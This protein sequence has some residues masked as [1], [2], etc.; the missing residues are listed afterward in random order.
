MLG[1]KLQVQYVVG[2]CRAGANTSLEHSSL[3][4][5]AIY[6]YVDG[7]QAVSVSVE[8]LDT[9]HAPDANNACML[10]A[11]LTHYVVMHCGPGG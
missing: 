10:N 11:V 6:F 1:R 8:V 3:V 4:H 9:V 5:S 7:P 2:S